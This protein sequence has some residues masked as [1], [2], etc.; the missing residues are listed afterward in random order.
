MDRKCHVSD[1]QGWEV[2]EVGHGEGAVEISLLSSW[3]GIQAGLMVL[4]FGVR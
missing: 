4:A 2:R 1:E 3:Q